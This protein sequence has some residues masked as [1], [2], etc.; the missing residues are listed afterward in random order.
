[1]KENGFLL[2]LF[3][4]TVSGTPWDWQHG[5]GYENFNKLEHQLRE[6]RNQPFFLKVNSY[7][8]VKQG[9][10]A[11][12]P[13]RVKSLGDYLVTW[14]KRSDVSVI[15]V[16]PN[17]FSSDN[18]YSIVHIPRARIDADDWTLL[19]NRTE[20]SDSGQY[21]CSLNTEP[22]LSHTV[23]LTVQ[24]EELF[25]PADSPLQSANP[26]TPLAHITGGPSLFAAAGDNIQLECRISGLKKPPLSLYWTKDGIVL[27]ARVR[28]GISLEVEKLPGISHSTLFLSNLNSKDSGEYSC[29][30]DV[31]PRANI[32]LVIAEGAHQS[33]VLA[34]LS[35]GTNI[36]TLFYLTFSSVLYSLLPSLV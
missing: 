1:M 6:L 5:S 27:N 12:L 35:S 26:S 9:E 20:V 7:V 18:R 30:S 17:I 2:L 32:S 14:L 4:Y 31:A 3:L 16:G 24:E 36:P 11:F 28:S 29:M 15:S 10:T 23:Y 13:C 8:K 22:K 34:S 19:I 33:P 21:F 25:L